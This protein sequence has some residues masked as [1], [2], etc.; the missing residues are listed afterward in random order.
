MR[1]NAV[2]ALRLPSRAKP[3]RTTVLSNKGGGWWCLHASAEPATPRSPPKLSGFRPRFPR[4]ACAAAPVPSPAPRS[5]RRA[6]A[7]AACGGEG[8]WVAATQ[9]AGRLAS[10]HTGCVLRQGRRGLGAVLRPFSTYFSAAAAR[11]FSGSTCTQWSS[12]FMWLSLVK[13]GRKA[14]RQRKV[15]SSGWHCWPP[16]SSLLVLFFSSLLSLREKY[17]RFAYARS[18]DRLPFLPDLKPLWTQC[19]ND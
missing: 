4:G 15:A 19:L 12:A 5:P 14:D 17:P 1:L 2:R 9:A 6:R 16:S 8:G 10:W 11:G 3:Q 18:V 7:A 13:G